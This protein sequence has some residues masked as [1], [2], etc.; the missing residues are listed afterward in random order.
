M[1][2]QIFGTYLTKAGCRGLL[3]L[4]LNLKPVPK[5]TETHGG[6]TGSS[7][8]LT[9]L[10]NLRL[11]IS[12]LT[13]FLLAPAAYAQFDT[14]TVLGTVTDE[15]GAAVSS[16]TVNLKN[17]ATGVQ[18]SAQT[19]GNGNYQFFN[20]K[21]GTYQV[22][23]E[24]QGFAR[25]VAENVQVTV[26]ARQRVDL[27]LKA[28]ALT[29]T[30]TVSADSVPLLETETSV[31]GQIIAREQIV[32][33]PLNG[34]AY[35]D[36][37]LLSP[38]V[39]K[40]VLNNQDSGGRDASFNVNGL[41]SSLNNFVLDGVDNN[42]YGTSNQGFSNQVVQA[43][44]DAV[45]EFQVQTN[46]FSAEFGRAGGAVINA[47]LRSGTNAFHGSVYAFIRNTSLNAVGFF[48]PTPP[49]G[50]TT[51][52]KPV[53][54]Q[55]QF[56]V[57]IG[58]PIIKDK[59]FFFFDYEGFRRIT[60]SLQLGTVPT[61]AQRNGQLGTPIR[62]PFT[63]EVY[64]DG[65]IPASA[66]TPFAR[67]VLAGLPLPTTSPNATGVVS[68]NFENLP[69]SKFYNDKG[70]LKIDQNFS[71]KTTAFVRISHRKLN[72]FEAPVIPAPIYSPA[73]AFVRVLNQQLAAGVT[74]NLTSNSLMEFR[75]GISRTQAGKTPTGVGDP[76]FQVPGLPTDPRFAGGLY[77]QNIGGYT[78]FGRQDSNPQFQNPFVVNPRFNYTF[79]AGRH[80]FKTG[81]EYQTIN[82]DID[83]FNPKYG[84]D[85]YS[86][87]FSRP[88]NITTNNNIYNLADFLFGARSQYDLNN[89]LIIKL[90]QRM[91]F[92]YLQDDFKVSQKLTL[93][94]GV[95]YEFATPQW[96]DE[97][98]LGNF[99]PATLTL[100]Q[101]KDG[102]IYDRA[103]VDPD[104]NNWAPRLGFAYQVFSKTVLRG[105]YGISYIHFNRLGGENLL[106]YNGPNIISNSVTQQVSQPLCT[107]NNF[108]GC[109]R[110]TEQGY[111]EGFVAPER[112]NPLTARVNFTPRDTRTAYVQS[113]HL[114]VQHE[115]PWELLLDV[116][117]VGNR[118]NKLIILGDYNQARP[119]NA[120]DP[121][122][123][124]PLQQR[125]PFPTYSF[126]QASFNGGFASYHALQIKLERRFAGGLYLLNSF[127]W[128]KAMDNAAGHLEANFGD[129][130]RGN[131][132]NLA[133]DK[134]LSNYDQ[135]FNNTT[136]VVY[137]LPFGKGRKFA[138]GIP[139]VLDYVIGGWRT[140]LIN[141]VSSGL[142]ANLTYSPASA[143]QVGSSLT[144][145]P[146][147]LLADLYTPEGQRDPVDY[148]NILAVSVPTDRSQPFGNA[149]RNTVRG[150]SFWQA[151]LGL[152]KSFPLW[153]E[154]T[155]LEFRVEAFNLFNRSNFQVPDT[156][157]SNI[158]IVNGVPA[159][160]GSY[161]R[162]TT[163]F[164]ARQIQFALKLLF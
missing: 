30:V 141:S 35:A 122:A 49:P 5:R 128:S 72:N 107:G 130:S 129:N 83:D 80:S 116:G 31:R 143:F 75:L 70:D 34:R 68:N 92:A 140:T 117:Y 51:G 52:V 32:N 3:F 22:T 43:S 155:R 111:P 134:G 53:L 8:S 37:A 63:G 159:P 121:A 36:L 77:T 89:A 109:F 160:G 103:L 112:F 124:T 78:S 10:F 119:N 88:T 23:A 110:K 151:D 29:E 90:H 59:T 118:S 7:I 137:D 87:Q 100:L 42:S 152:H 101:A 97:N 81:Y 74:H 15:N 164:P 113:W 28:G 9:I 154:S 26:N 153:R 39:R 115:L 158:R 44:P 60:R 2:S 4:N 106:S 102:S 162:I 161:G 148:L 55:N 79:V 41:R 146:N 27:A 142:P 138:S 71:S 6:I 58:G 50:R 38:G 86:G 105:G 18:A 104:R 99:D 12:L 147:Q 11:M 24:A 123:G 67:A 57:T 145:R 21:I 64:A 62:N 96:E 54:I 108:L 17:V 33:L 16:A 156:N 46:N 139:T 25:G 85:T 125:R 66:I 19:D 150:P 94:L 133:N 132:K 61:A 14:A 73:N 20:V 135:P 149:G 13:V 65:N 93:N 163:T 76:S 45:Q 40:S 84:R 120:S 126:I 48:K 56:G 144:Y 91:H 157:A 47:S 98:R 69:R 136:S 127:T 131:I 95:R 82:T 1:Q 114:T